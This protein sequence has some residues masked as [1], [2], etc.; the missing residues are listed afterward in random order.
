MRGIMGTMKRG[1]AG[2]TLIE[3]M[4]TVIII[5]IV[6]AIALPALMGTKRSFQANAEVSQFFTEL[7]VRQDQYHTENGESLSTGA[8]EAATFPAAPAPHGAN[9]TA[10]SMPATWNTKLKVQLP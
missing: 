8:S 4:I 10:S 9:I 3:M 5:G 6:A 1:E 2:F 7:R